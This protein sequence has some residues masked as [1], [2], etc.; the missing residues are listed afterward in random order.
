MIDNSQIKKFY[1]KEI[2]GI[3]AFAV[4]A[5]CFY[6][7]NEKAL[8]SG[9]LG[10]DMFFVISGYV[11]TSSLMRDKS[12]NFLNFVVNFY[13]RRIRRIFPALVFFIL[14]FSILICFFNPTPGLSLW[15]GITSL[16][17]VSNYYL[18]QKTS[19]YFA[20]PNNLNVFINTWS[21]GVEEQFYL[22]FPFIFWFSGISKFTKIGKKVFVNS[23]LFISII[24]LISFVYLYTN[25]ISIAYYSMPTR[26]WE[27]SVGCLIFLAFNI[28]SKII[29]ILRNL[30]S[31][32]CL[33]LISL[34]M[35]L[36]SS[37]GGL[38]HIF[39]VILTALLLLCLKENS[40]LYEILTNKKIVN[41]G[42]ISYSLYLWH[43]GI[44]S[45]SY[46]TIGL[47][48]WSI[49]FQVLLIYYLSLF[50]YN[51]VEKPFRKTK[52]LI[53]VS[54]TYMT[55]LF[56]LCFAL[57]G[58]VILGK[59]LKGKLFLG[60]FQNYIDSKETFYYLDDEDF[61][62][63]N[64]KEIGY[65][66]R[67]RYAKCFANNKEN[68]RTLFFIGDSHNLSLLAGSELVA[69]KFESNLY[70]AFGKLFPPI[71]GNNDYMFDAYNEIIN[72]AK[73]DDIVFITLRMPYYFLNKPK[74]Y[75]Y[76]EKTL[77]SWINEVKDFS[78]VLLKKN[79]NIIIST[80]TPEF[81]YGEIGQCKSQNPQ[82]FN[83]LGKKYCSKSLSYFYSQDGIYKEIIN[84]IKVLTLENNIYLFDG[85]KAMCP[86]NECNF[87]LNKKVLYW[88]SNHISHYG[89]KYLLAPAII[90]FLE[91]ERL[92]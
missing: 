7:I 21:L 68:K 56:T 12:T 82:W 83:Q 62:P 17:G 43:W 52:S 45:I 49:P 4:L 71:E 76:P 26:F 55:G 88:D 47:H 73:K 67:L 36:P 61:C 30:P 23:I 77:K 27:I 41:I 16:L 65:A 48:W 9:F 34:I 60:N 14:V 80:P 89:S 10:V 3:R 8:P 25:N 6:H 5:V 91:S 79:V 22:L 2:D 35:I 58:I 54:Q 18:I 19:N 13:E 90:R 11:I 53:K 75:R 32:L 63:P 86:E 81:S 50:S 51:F 64:I 28:N 39:V 84:K 57:I 74:D 24:S 33:I 40:I 78:K 46:W 85:L 70:F 72:S 31:T 29:N 59:P 92:I 87:S 1:R 69:K 42:H 20:D 37:F 44:L 66:N 15:T 38:S